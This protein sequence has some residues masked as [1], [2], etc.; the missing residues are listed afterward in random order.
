MLQYY[1]L[2]KYSIPIL[3]AM[4]SENLTKSMLNAH[5]LVVQRLGGECMSGVCFL[6]PFK[7]VII[8]RVKWGKIGMELL[9]W[10]LEG[11]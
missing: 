1:F 4:S 11:T 9:K 7:C 6:L 5:N 2:L 10:V 8:K 3:Y